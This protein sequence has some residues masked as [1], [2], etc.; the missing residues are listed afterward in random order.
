[1]ESLPKAKTPVL[2]EHGYL[3]SGGLW[4]GEGKYPVRWLLVGTQVVHS[5][6]VT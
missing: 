4:Q 6:C 2:R 1:M 3:P 5:E